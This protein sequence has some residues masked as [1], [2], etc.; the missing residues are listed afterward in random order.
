MERL[1]AVLRAAGEPTRLRILSSCAQGDLT[2]SELM[3]IL[4]QSQPRVSRHLKL[5]CEAGLLKRFQ[6]GSWAFFHLP[7]NG[8]EADIIRSLIAQ[9]GDDDPLITGDRQRL[10]E[11]RLARAERAASYFRDSAESWDRVR[12]LHVDEAEVEIAILNMLGDEI[13]ETLL[14]I[15]TGTGRMLQLLGPRVQDAVGVDQSHDMLSVARTN[16]SDARYANCSVRQADMYQLP[17]ENA[18]FDLV[19]LHMVLHFADEPVDVVREA[20]RVLRPGGCFLIVDFAPHEM[21]DLRTHHAHRRLGFRAEE[22]GGWARA[23]G[24]Q[25]IDAHELPGKPL[26]VKIWKTR[27]P[28]DVHTLDEDMQRRASA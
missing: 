23:S 21:E 13:P 12:A 17:F 19:V 15:G 28:A 3:R 14:D 10:A 27:R 26:T 20:A 18:S 4:G 11:I 2:V 25:P 8:P 16:L 24:L 5:L 22:V 1:L 6:E 9:V 7:V